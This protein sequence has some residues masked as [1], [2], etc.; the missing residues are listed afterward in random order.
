MLRYGKRAPVKLNYHHLLKAVFNRS[1]VDPAKFLFPGFSRNNQCVL[2][3]IISTCHYRLNSTLTSLTKTKMELHISFLNTQGLFKHD[4]L[5]LSFSDL[6]LFEKMN[7]P[8]PED[9]VRVFPTLKLFAGFSI[10]IFCIRKRD[11]VF[12]VFPTSLS[13]NNRDSSYFQ[14][15]LLE[16]T[17]DILASPLSDLYREQHVLSVPFLSKLITKF[18]LARTN[19]SKYIYLCR[20]CLSVFTTALSK[21]HHNL[22][23]PSAVRR[24]STMPRKRS[25]NQFL[26]QPFIVNRFTGR[27]E[28]NS[29]KFR[30]SDNH[31]TLMPL[32]IGWMDLESFSGPMPISTSIYEKP[33]RSA[34][35]QQRSMSWAYVFSSPYKE[36]PL[37]TNLNLPRI[38]FCAETEDSDERSL[39]IAL[40]L[41]MRSDLESHLKHLESVLVKDL[42]A[43]PT[44]MRNPRLVQYIRSV[45]CCQLCGSV[46]GRKKF[47]V[48]S[49][50]YYETKRAFDHCHLTNKTQF[51]SLS[52]NLRAVLCQVSSKEFSIRQSV[53]QSVRAS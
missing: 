36:I 43:N 8:I 12:R 37:P 17:S 2:G 29:L 9:L 45:E 3:G 20:S 30:R 6:G 52:S 32:S 47:S 19:W 22:I 25:R 39:Y 51:P 28:V 44:N 4:R 1:V 40:F 24:G 13:P 5:G 49:Q 15:D 27:T 7:S 46:F 50:K 42:G 18:T 35:S 48:V 11:N 38:R 10:N 33:P 23:C 21:Q 31:K 26:H 14:I 41:S 16:V 53:C 34:I